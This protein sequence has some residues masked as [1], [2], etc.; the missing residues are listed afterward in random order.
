[1]DENMKKFHESEAK[2]CFN[3]TWD[4]LEKED[5]SL[6]DDLNMI[7][8]A[9]ASRYH[10]GIVGEPVHHERGEWL[11][12]KVYY[13]LNKGEQALYHAEACYRIC[14]LYKIMD[15]D[16]AFAYEALANA[17]K[18][19]NHFEKVNLYKTKAFE[20]LDQIKDPED[21]AYTESELKKI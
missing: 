2:K 5:R 9:H 18:L 17:H 6:E 11:I 21:R 16:I 19:L 1:M 8:L 4:Y 13:T 3:Q 15:F 12:S 10:W 7:H 20:H 14:D